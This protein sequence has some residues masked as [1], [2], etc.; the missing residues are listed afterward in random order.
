[1]NY[2]GLV[3]A[4]NSA[5]TQLQGRAA[6]AVNHALVIRNWMVG[7]SIVEFEQH[8]RDRAKYGE[9]L[10]ESLAADMAKKEIAG[11]NV[12]ILDRCRVFYR[13]YPMLRAAIPATVS[14][15]FLV[16]DLAVEIPATVSPEFGPLSIRRTQSPELPTPLSPELLL[17]LTWSQ[18]QELIRLDD[19]WKRAFYENECLQGNWSVRQLQRQIGS[20]LYERTGLSTRKKAVIERARRQE[21]T[22][23]VADLL[24]DPYVLEFAGLSELPAYSEDQL[25]TTLLDH[26]QRFLLELGRGFCFEA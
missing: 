14:P 20:L 4:I 7:A 2:A 24:R 22:E 26:L 3:K 12:R 9:R 5:T 25:E 16:P 8:G 21:P 6:A 10:L 17:R 19:P 11:L 13:T 1:M 15:E 23:T 18:F